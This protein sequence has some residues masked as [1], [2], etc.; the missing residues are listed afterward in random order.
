VLAPLTAWS[1]ATYRAAPTSTRPSLVPIAATAA[2]ALVGLS[3]LDFGSYRSFVSES[4]VYRFDTARIHAMTSLT[5]DTTGLLAN[6]PCIDAQ[7]LKI[8]TRKPVAFY[9]AGLA[10]PADKGAID[11]V[12]DASRN[13]TFDPDAMRSAKVSYLVTDSACGVVWPVDTTM[14]VVSVGT[15][16]Y[17]DEISSGTLTLWKIA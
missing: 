14:G 9:N 16:D 12:M 8:A 17:A 5:S 10:W 11:A 6:G 2:I 4:G 1:I 15:A 13:G 3:L 7:E